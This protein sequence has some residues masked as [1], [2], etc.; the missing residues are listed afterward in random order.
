MRRNDHGVIG[1]PMVGLSLVAFI[2]LAVAPAVSRGADRVVLAEEFT[3][4]W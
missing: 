4:T 2:G 1:S 3:A